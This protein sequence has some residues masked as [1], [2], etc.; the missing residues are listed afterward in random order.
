MKTNEICADCSVRHQSLC[1]SLDDAELAEFNRIGR[2]RRLVAGENIVWAGGESLVCGNVLSGVLKLSAS[3][4][5]GREQ[6][7]GLLFPAD[8]IGRP[9]S[10]ATDFSICALSEA[11]LCLFPRGPFEQLLGR[12]AGME[13]ALLKRTL[14][15]LD[16][17]R[18][19]M[20]MLSRQSA[21]VKVAAFLLDMAARAQSNACRAT[22]DGPLT[23]DLP[24]TRGQIAD[25]LGLTI[26]TV[27]RQMTKFKAAAIIALPTVRGVTI[28]DWSALRARAQLG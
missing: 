7:V 6:I 20:V 11:E 2:R 15:A 13:R 25:V 5:D 10:D 9:Y 26:E 16:Q 22:V 24:L 4:P 8:F 28:R 14:T 18:L 12:N 3:T 19:R 21:D 27:S 23:F 1:G 17:T